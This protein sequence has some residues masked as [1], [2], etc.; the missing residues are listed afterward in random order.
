MIQ[1]IMNRRF[2]VVSGLVIMNAL[3]FANVARAGEG[4][5][6]G[7][8][9]FTV[10]SSNVTGVAVSA[11]VGKDSAI[12]HAFNYNVPAAGGL[13]NSAFAIGSAGATTSENIGGATFKVT[14]AADASLNTAQGNT[15]G[16]GYSIQ[17]GTSSGAVLN[18]TPAASGSTGPGSTGP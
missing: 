7:S 4:G 9:A 13:Q 3:G 14:A 1:N 16:N 10:N 2:A 17:L 15:I 12:A 8:A 5:I 11:A 18:Q 6:A